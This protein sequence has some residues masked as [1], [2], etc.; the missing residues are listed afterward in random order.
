MAIQLND[1]HPALAIPELMR[2]LIDEEGLDFDHA[3]VI[4]RQTCCY[5]NHTLLPEA[6]EKWPQVLISRILP[7]HLQIIHQIN[8]IFLHDEVESRWPDDNIM[9]RRLSIIEEPEVSWKQPKVRM[10]HLATIGSNRVNGVAALHTQ[11]IKQ[12]LL[13]A[14]HTLWPEKIVNV[15]N[16]VTPRRWLASCNPGLATLL[17]EKIKGEW[18]RDLG[19]LKQL[20]EYAEDTEFQQQYA[21]VKLHNK[22]QLAKVIEQVCGVRVSTNAIF[23]V[24]IKRLHEY[25]RQHMNLLHIMV[26]YRRLLENP[27][28]NI[29]ARVFIFGAKAATSYH[30]AKSIIHAINCLAERVNN[31]WRI[32][33]KL[34]VVFLP[35]YRVSLAEK[36]IP[37]ADVSEQIS[38]AGLE[39]SGTGN[40]K[41][42]INGALT[43]GTLDGANV[44]IAEEAGEDNLFIFGMTAGEVKDKWRQGYAPLTLYHQHGELRAVLD[45][46]ASGDLCQEQPD[47]FRPLVNSLKES[48]YFMALADFHAYSDAQERIA[49]AWKQPELW[50][51][52]AIMNTASLGKFSS[53]RA[54]MDYAKTIWN[55][56]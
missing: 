46:L 56:R 39:A 19:L 12:D 54:V 32:K 53:D 7:R 36:I 26:L 13:P 27:E 2:L 43:I 51:K 31:D 48:D 1:T 42:A 35:N 15:T 10:A 47:A 8:H 28:L 38:T 23:D 34:K 24:H 14:F 33:N 55:V 18:R 9:K 3:L 22:Q 25:K 40:M 20:K 52:M 11:L 44:E 41:L 30:L 45:W 37:A 17:D 21:A 5:T 29:P 49:A 4:C 50:W 6:L 16:G